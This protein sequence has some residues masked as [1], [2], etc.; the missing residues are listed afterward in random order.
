M[1]NQHSNDDHQGFLLPDALIALAVVALTVGLVT[2]T[3]LV[4]QRQTH[5]REERLLRARLRHDQALL[6]W[7]QE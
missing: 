1:W 7:A 6:K 5:A 2:Q 3:V 4:V